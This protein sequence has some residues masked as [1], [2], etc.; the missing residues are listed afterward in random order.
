MKRRLHLGNT[1]KGITA[2]SLAAIATS[3]QPVLAEEE[4]DDLRIPLHSRCPVHLDHPP[5]LHH[6]PPL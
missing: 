4:G 1:L 5:G 6:L 2:A 3:V